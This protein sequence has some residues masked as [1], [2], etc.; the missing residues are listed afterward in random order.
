MRR[1]PFGTA[2]VLC[3]CWASA[4]RAG[5][6]GINPV[7]LTLEPGR[8]TGALTVRND[9]AEPTVVQIEVTRWSQPDGTEQLQPTRELLATPPIFDLAPGAT[10]VVRVGLRGS[11]P[12]ERR[13]RAYRLLL[14]EVPPAPGSAAK[15]VQIALNISL[16]VFVLPAGPALPAVSLRWQARRIDGGL[17]LRADNDGPVHVQVNGLS[18]ASAGRLPRFTPGYLL[19]GAH[20]EWQVRQEAAA[21]SALP[22]VAHTDAG[23]L[24]AQVLVGAP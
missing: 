17:W 12:E 15:G 23:D 10:Q 14:K 2:L 1:R 7:R 21:G 18:L 3:M 24:A 6:L 13:E 20:R 4:A 22:L 9:S 5:A 19:P 11:V 16:P 8:A